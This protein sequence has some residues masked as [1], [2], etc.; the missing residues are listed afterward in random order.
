MKFIGK[1][2]KP[3]KLLPFE[4][5]FGWKSQFRLCSI[6]QDPVQIVKER[7]ELIKNSNPEKPLKKKNK[8]DFKKVIIGDEARKIVASGIL[9]VSNNVALTYGPLG[10]NFAISNYNDEPIITK[11]G[12]TVARYVNYSSRKESLGVRL[13]SA[14]SGTTNKFAGDGTT[15]SSVLTGRLIKRGVDFVTSGYEASVLKDGMHFY[16]EILLKVIKELRIGISGKKAL[17]DLSMITSNQDIELSDIISTSV[18]KMGLD[19]EIILEESPYSET[20]LVETMALNV[21]NGIAS[22]SLINNE[23][24]FTA[25]SPLILITS[26]NLIN[27]HELQGVIELV[28]EINRSL[29]IISPSVSQD[30]INY[31]SFTNSKSKD[32]KIFAVNLPDYMDT[33]HNIDVLEDIAVATGATMLSQYDLENNI[34]EEHLGSCDIVTFSQFETIL[35]KPNGDKDALKDRLDELQS[36]LSG[37]EKILTDPWI[38]IIKRR[39]ATLEQK[40]CM[41]LVGGESEVEKVN[42]RDKIVDCINSCR[43]AIKSGILIGGGNAYIHALTVCD[44]II[45]KFKDP[46]FNSNDNLIISDKHQVSIHFSDLMKEYSTYKQFEKRNDCNDFWLGSTVVRESF[47]DLIRIL[48]K[49]N[50]GGW[51]GD[52]II[53][54][55]QKAYNEVPK[56]KMLFGYSIKNSKQY[57]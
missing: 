19:G 49:N 5:K 47:Y 44:A 24:E 45:N 13:L 29:L 41:I 37:N 1:A 17:Y 57:L 38:E 9:K 15:T 3:L 31:M 6:T 55:Y 4:F 53:Q 26:F 35:I 18:L 2:A 54:E 52:K 33:N 43:T 34:S 50:S 30:L 14:V 36:Y 23:T 8:Y 48:Y 25:K 12:V 46:N 39:I 20:L 40:S 11:D 16:K 27:Q 10:R 7:E 22:V 51:S 32:I 21:P 56:D 28:K 42:N